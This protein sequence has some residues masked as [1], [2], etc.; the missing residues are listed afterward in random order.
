[1][2]TQMT[3]GLKA[4]EIVKRVKA[5][6]R[7]RAETYAY[8]DELYQYAYGVNFRGGLPTE[9]IKHGRTRLGRMSKDLI[10]AR[11]SLSKIRKERSV[12]C[13]QLDE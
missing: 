4:S 11:K 3:E 1:M 2:S 8:I 6:K 12:L 9:E 7:V 5:F 10:A 13:Q